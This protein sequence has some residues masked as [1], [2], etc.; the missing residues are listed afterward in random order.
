[1]LYFLSAGIQ[2]SH[3]SPLWSLRSIYM[4]SWV[5]LPLYSP[6]TKLCVDYQNTVRLWCLWRLSASP[7]D[8]SSFN[9]PFL[10]SPIC[11]P[12]PTQRA[13]PLDSDGP[14]FQAKSTSNSQQRQ[15]VASLTNCCLSHATPWWWE[16]VRKPPLSHPLI[17]SICSL[18]S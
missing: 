11:S 6:L 1:M 7:C 15:N 17:R 5:W 3:I 10:L 16:S 18:L 13:F 2:E 14:S 9:L 12:S 4:L 8:S